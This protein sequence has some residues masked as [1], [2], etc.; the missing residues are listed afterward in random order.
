MKDNELRGIILKKL[1]DKRREGFIGLTEKDFNNSIPLANIY[2]IT[3]QL[4][5]YGMIKSQSIANTYDG[6]LIIKDIRA[7]IA[8]PGTDVIEGNLSPPIGITF[9]DKSINVTSSSNFQ[10]GNQNSLKVEQVLKDIHDKIDNADA[11]AQDKKQAKS[12]WSAISE[13]PL[14]NTILGSVLS[15]IVKPD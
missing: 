11:S 6:K 13:N 10:I 1:Y 12:L 8:A 14:L 3:E 4:N 2:R 15:N 7:T 9:I 5:D